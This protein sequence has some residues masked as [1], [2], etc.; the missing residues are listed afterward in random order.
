MGGGPPKEQR[1]YRGYL[2]SP[3][4]A[5]TERHRSS[6]TRIKARP[7]PCQAKA[8]PSGEIVTMSTGV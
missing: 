3:H 4:Q 2:P 5:L 7:C 6:L 1:C 8:L